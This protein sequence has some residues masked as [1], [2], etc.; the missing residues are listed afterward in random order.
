MT[1]AL[2][3]DA[4]EPAPKKRSASSGVLPAFVS[5]EI[6]SL[7]KELPASLR[8]G[9]S[10]WYFPGWAGLVWDQ[11]YA[12]A[13]LSKKGL[14]AYCQHPLLRTVSLDRAFYR[15]MQA[16]QYAQLAEQVD[17]DF[18][19]VVKVPSM[20]SDAL[21]RSTEGNKAGRGL[22]SNPHFLDAKIF[23][24]ICLQPLLE[25]LKHQLGA[26]VLQI[27]PMPAHMLS[28]SEIS[29]LFGQL[30]CI[31]SAQSAIKN[32]VPHALIAVELRNPEFIS[33]P[34][35]E[36]LIALLKDTGAT[37]CL[38]LHAKLPPIEDQLPILRKLWPGPLV[39]RW[40]LH[41]KHG[42]FGY[43]SALSSY[44]PFNKL[45][46]EDMHTREQLARVIAGTLK[47]GQKAL[48][49]INNKAEGSAPLS[50]AK[51]GTAVLE[52]ISR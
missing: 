33:T 39:C 31:L 23:H 51:L 49:T 32:I 6:Q 25:G 44:E 29:K 11:P 28:H 45:V 36:E 38:G 40:N 41:S 1:L 16:E 4:P 13:K 21:I 26:L 9:T 37:Y 48:V 27:S 8:L 12:E 5:P 19:F 52:H 34:L 46:D 3:D 47:G 15:P 43:E 50:V 14:R 7:A 42:R 17:D 10:S 2:F 18:R 30:A 22:Q 20:I 24:E 35:R